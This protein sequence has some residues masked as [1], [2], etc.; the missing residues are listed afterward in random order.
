MNQVNIETETTSSNGGLYVQKDV[1]F[2]EVLIPTPWKTTPSEYITANHYVEEQF[3]KISDVQVELNSTDL[4]A[5]RSGETTEAL[6]NLKK[7][8]KYSIDSEHVTIFVEY[9][10]GQM[11]EPEEMRTILDIQ[12]QYGDILSTPIQT[13]LIE[14]LSPYMSNGNLDLEHSPYDAIYPTIRHFLENISDYS[15][16]AMGILPLIGWERRR[17]LLREYESDGI[18]LLGLDYR[19][20]KPTTDKLFNQ[21]LNLI[22]D[23]AARD[24]LSNSV[25]YAFN[26][27]SYHPTKNGAPIPSEAIAQ[28]TFGVDILGGCHTYRGAGGGGEITDVK[29]FNSNEFRFDRVELEAIPEQFPGGST[30][31]PVDLSEFGYGKRT[32]L[33]KLINSELI[34]RGLR[35]LRAAIRDGFER[36]FM[37]QKSGYSGAVKEQAIAVANKYDDATGENLVP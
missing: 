18:N 11:I 12:S 3:Q 24:Q 20:F 10:S 36:E 9:P 32:N 25:L 16:P 37:E 14:T 27:K 19:G 13:D 33:R 1:D 4:E 7:K 30:I 29:I 28:A 34:S 21:H 6:T 17:E 15:E 8:L 22:S 23:L 31:N 35:K 2:G 5:Y 26:Y